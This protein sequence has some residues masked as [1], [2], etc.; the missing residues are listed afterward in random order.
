M[1]A[2]R[3]SNLISILNVLLMTGSSLT[4]SPLV[5]MRAHTN[6]QKEDQAKKTPIVNPLRDGIRDWFERLGPVRGAIVNLSLGVVGA[7]PYQ[8]KDAE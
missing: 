1:V 7:C 3:A 5:T 8:P 4:F 2:D 6:G